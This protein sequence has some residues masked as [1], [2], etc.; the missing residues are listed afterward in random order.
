MLEDAKRLI[1]AELGAEAAA[2]FERGTDYQRRQIFDELGW[3]LMLGDPDLADGTRFM[4]RNMRGAFLNALAS[5]EIY[6]TLQSEAMRTGMLKALLPPKDGATD[7]PRSPLQTEMMILEAELQNAIKEDMR[8]KTDEELIANPSVERQ[9]IVGKI[10]R[11][12]V[13]AAR[14]ASGEIVDDTQDIEIGGERRGFLQAEP[15]RGSGR[16]SQAACGGAGKLNLS[17]PP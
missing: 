17:L 13:I 4:G 12:L 10:T 6:D 5:L 2:D 11:A 1:T 8:T 3:R 14:E 9:R 16:C 7:S 15:Q